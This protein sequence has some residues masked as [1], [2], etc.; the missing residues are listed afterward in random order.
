[1]KR[2]L[3]QLGAGL[4]SFVRELGGTALLTQRTFAAAVRERPSP[5][6]FLSS[7]D[8]FG[9]ASLPVLALTALLTGGILV[10]QSGLVVR[11]F[12]IQTLVGWGVGYGVL[13]QIG[14]LLSGLLFNGR[15]GSRNAAELAAMQSREQLAGLRAMG[16]DPLAAVVAPRAV[17]MVVAL[18]ALG[19]VSSAIAI[20]GGV[21][22][23]WAL[24]GIEPGVF[25][26]SLQAHV[27]LADVGANAVKVFV[28]G[29]AVAAVS[30]RCGLSAEGGAAGVGTAAAR[31]VVRAALAII[32]LDLGV[33]LL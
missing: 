20:G 4:L 29:V 18:V 33:S 21:V 6:L 17:A 12:G 2:L 16:V 32:V 13:R 27:T 1:V 8:R 24:L 10:I 22:T 9:A 5:K 3:S 14:P 19:V 11:R 28:F 31:S 30:C 25:L 15:V 7:L 23:A 26:R